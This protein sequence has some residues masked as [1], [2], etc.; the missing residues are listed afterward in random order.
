[1]K[2]TF[3]GKL[4]V[5]MLCFCSVIS[6]CAC[7]SNDNQSEK[8]QA[9]ATTLINL[10]VNPEVELLLN[11][12][13]VVISATG[14]NNDGCYL[15]CDITLTGQ[16]AEDALNIYLQACKDKGFIISNQQVN[17]TI[18]CT[19]DEN[20]E[21]SVKLKGKANDFK[22]QTGITVNAEINLLN[23]SSLEN[24][25]SNCCTYLSST[26]ISVCSQ[27]KLLQLISSARK[28]AEE[29]KLGTTEATD[30]YY[31]AKGYEY[32]KTKANKALELIKNDSALKKYAD[33][34]QS[35]VSLL[36]QNVSF[37]LKSYTDI[38][39]SSECAYKKA[40]TELYSKQKDY[41]NARING[42]DY[43]QAQ[44]LTNQAKEKV[45]NIKDSVQN[46][47]SMFLNSVNVCTS[48]LSAIL[49]SIS[50]SPSFNYNTVA[51]YAQ[52]HIDKY[53]T[54]FENLF[55]DC[56]LQETPW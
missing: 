43:S 21:L 23:K 52:E 53:Y 56:N 20:S 47:T 30:F 6:L 26:E 9:S 27:E 46:A 10:S 45:Q 36:E 1:M 44:E 15:L 49:D 25:V 42:T 54:S 5:F 14:V 51:T 8:K 24:I 35:A 32:L 3:F 40:L 17:L 13:D 22:N 34:L 55:K 7:G 41:L 38:V 48:G 12:N 11:E 37:Y 16:S 29:L 2:K 31:T 19:Q 28:E 50:A 4:I 18:E 33:S 39:F